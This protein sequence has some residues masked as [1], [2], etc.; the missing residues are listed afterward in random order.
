LLVWIAHLSL[1]TLGD[2][3]PTLAYL[4]ASEEEE[5]GSEVQ[6]YTSLGEIAVAVVFDVEDARQLP[7]TT[8]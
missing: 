5:W 6:T 4:A 7:I 3:P 8:Y 2:L 1:I